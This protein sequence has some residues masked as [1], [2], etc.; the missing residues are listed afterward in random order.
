MRLSTDNQQH[1]M[2]MA[3][4]LP[5]ASSDPGLPIKEKKNTLPRQETCST[6]LVQDFLLRRG[7]RVYTP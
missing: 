6:V 2:N 4:R 5:E 1:S 7:K 3:T